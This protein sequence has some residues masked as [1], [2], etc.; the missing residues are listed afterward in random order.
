MTYNALTTVANATLEKKIPPGQYAAFPQRAG[1]DPTLVYILF[2][3]LALY[4]LSAFITMLGKQSF[5]RYFRVDIYGSPISRG[6]D[7]QRKRE[8]MVTW[9]FKLDEESTSDAPSRPSSP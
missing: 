1:P 3:S 4:P 9:G 5:N 8:G 6:R 7:Q 2:S